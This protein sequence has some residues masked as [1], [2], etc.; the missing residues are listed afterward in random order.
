M[1]WSTNLQA[2][3]MLCCT[4]GSEGLDMTTDDGGSGDSDTVNLSSDGGISLFGFKIGVFTAVGLL[5][6]SIITIFT[7]SSIMI[8]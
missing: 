6:T 3:T 7:L 2:V 4:A 5:L 1:R 8:L